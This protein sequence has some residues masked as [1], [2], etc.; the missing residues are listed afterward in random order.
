MMKDPLKLISDL[1]DPNPFDDDGDD[2][3]GFYFDSWWIF[4]LSIGVG[5]LIPAIGY[6][7]AYLNS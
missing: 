6:L 5:L 1:F 4:F 2:G 3:I 7:L